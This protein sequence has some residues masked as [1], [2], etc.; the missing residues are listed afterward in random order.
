[1]RAIVHDPAATAGLRLADVSDPEPASNEVLV[2]VAAASLNFLDVAYR[3][4]RMAAGAVPGVDAAG[5]VIAAARDGSGPAAGSRVA[6]FG[7]GGA[8]A[9]QRAVDTADVAILPDGV[10]ID[11][12]AALPAAGVT[13]L[14]AVRKLGPLLGRRVLVTGA[15][16]GV[17][18]FAVQLA[19][20]AGAYVVAAVGSAKRGS[21]L[22]ELGAREVVTELAGVQ[23]VHGVIENVGGPLLGEAFALLTDGGVALSVGQASGQPTTFDFEE[24]R[25]RGGNRRV[26]AFVVGGGHS[27]DLG[28]LL[29]LV[30]RGL[31]DPQIGWRGPWEQVG[32]AAQALIERRL[33]GKVV[34]E[35]G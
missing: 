32:D 5:V 15:S 9:E 6:T 33:T 30:A 26:E 29:D 13:A 7:S 3:H 20:Q 34:I 1:M 16:G 14:R 2:Q 18:R 22:T 31:L 11:V 8:W 35:I 25:V 28:V 4:D 19:S 21:G 17:G 23:P 12:A 10:D 24:E 27:D